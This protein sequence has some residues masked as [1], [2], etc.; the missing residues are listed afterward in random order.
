[1][2]Y[3]R[4][5]IYNNL[6]GDLRMYLATVV[7][8]VLKKRIYV[9]FNGTPANKIQWYCYQNTKIIIWEMLLEN[10]F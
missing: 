5:D 9:C 3:E 1:M 8:N 4:S 10:A 7:L 6:F 2:W